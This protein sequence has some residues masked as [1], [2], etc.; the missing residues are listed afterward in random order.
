MRP[1][2]ATFLDVR[3]QFQGYHMWPDAPD[4]VAFLRSLHRHV[5]HVRLRLKVSADR[6]EEFFLVQRKMIECSVLKA[7][8]QLEKTP[9]LSCESIAEIYFNFFYD[10]K[11]VVEEVEVTEDNENGAIVRVA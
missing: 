10:R 5:F 4:E 1:E 6:E 8:P 7:L 9:E 3:H 2:L 11:Y